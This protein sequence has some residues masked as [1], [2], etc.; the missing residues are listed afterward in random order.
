LNRLT[1]I[2]LKSPPPQKKKIYPM[3]DNSALQHHNKQCSASHN[4]NAECPTENLLQYG[5]VCH[6]PFI[7]S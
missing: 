5:T 7:N 2:H 1:T 4:P 3:Q 6:T